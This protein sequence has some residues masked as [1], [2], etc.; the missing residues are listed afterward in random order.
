M[1][2]IWIIELSNLLTKSQYHFLLDDLDS[3]KQ[4]R[5][6]RYRMPKDA[7]CSLL[8]DI[9]IRTLIFKHLSLCK[10][11]IIFS[12]NTYGKPFL[13][14]YEDF[15]F[16]I[17]HSGKYVACAVS[18]Q[19]IGIDIEIVNPIDLA[20]ANRFFVKDE[21]QYILNGNPEYLQQR[22]YSI[23]TRKEAY[24]KLCGKGLYIPLHSFN[25]LVPQTSIAYLCIHKEDSAI[26]HICIKKK[27]LPIVQYFSAE[28]LVSL[29]KSYRLVNQ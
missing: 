12:K 6:K 5:L 3:E 10:R 14:G 1:I 22:F 20:F 17:S 8:G 13:Q 24:I 21:I 9:A 2:E 18:N 7:H 27:E 28:T 15:H 4:Q 29:Y 26:C 23:W 19:P 16:N 11:E 25:V